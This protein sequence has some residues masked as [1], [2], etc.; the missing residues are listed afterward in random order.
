MHHVN[1]VPSENVVRV[2]GQAE[3]VD[4]ALLL[5]QDIHAITWFGSF[6]FGEIQYLT[7]LATG[8]RKANERFE[9]FAPYQSFADLWF[10]E[11]KKEKVTTNVA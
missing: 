11:A 10:I 4:C 1:I 7:D 3:T 9:N 5:A 2:E 8:T 6:E